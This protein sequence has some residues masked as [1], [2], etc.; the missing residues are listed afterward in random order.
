MTRYLSLILN[1][2][3]ILINYFVFKLFHFEE[4]II[5][6]NAYYIEFMIEANFKYI[7]LASLLVVF[8]K[9]LC[10]AAEFDQIV[11]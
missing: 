7:P 1:R 11:C 3:V 6:I 8:I 2:Q 9:F 10:E 5:F 4:I